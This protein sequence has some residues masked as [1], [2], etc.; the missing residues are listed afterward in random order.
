MDVKKL[1][2]IRFLTRFELNG[3]NEYGARLFLTERA[4]SRPRRAM[5][6]VARHG[7]LHWQNHPAIG[8]RRSRAQNTENMGLQFFKSCSSCSFSNYN[9]FQSSE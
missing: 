7:Q 2:L 4:W 5:L 1:K 3:E 6:S 8:F 9:L